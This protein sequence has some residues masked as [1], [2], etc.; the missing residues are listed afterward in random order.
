METTTPQ[1]RDKNDT[2]GDGFIMAVLKQSDF[3]K[4][5]Q[6]VYQLSGIRLMS[7][8]EELVRSRL[9]KRLRALSISS[10]SKYL[11]YMEND[12]SSLELSI[13]VDLL[14][15]NKT[16]F[17][18]EKQHFEFLRAH[19]LPILRARSLGARVWSAGCSSGEEPYSIAMLMHEEWPDAAQTGI[20]ILAT[21]ISAR[22]LNKARIGEYQRD[23]VLEVPP[24]MLSNCFTLVRNN[25]ERIYR[26]NENIRNMIRFGR[27]N[28]M[29]E[30][31][32]K[33]GFDVIFCRNVMIYFD[34]ETQQELVRR[35]YKMINP[36]GYLLIG[37]SESLA[38]ASCGF[39]YIQPATYTKS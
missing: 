17:F 14:T 5:S 9:M 11:Q 36:G 20:R 7:G 22:M 13:M 30:W 18:R 25:P 29:G 6:I 39:K 10:F 26:V 33:G 8:K 31:P 1:F 32:M 19:I 23:D 24:L 34:T 4:I 2:A 3:E 37:H 35:F 21:D 38:A 28:L 15:T 16:S 12:R 27:L